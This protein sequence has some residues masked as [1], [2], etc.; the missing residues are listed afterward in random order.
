[1]KQIMLRFSRKFKWKVYINWIHY[2][3]SEGTLVKKQKG[4]RSKGT[5]RK[6]HCWY[7]RPSLLI[8][9]FDLIFVFILINRSDWIWSRQCTDIMIWLFVCLFFTKLF[10]RWDEQIPWF[11]DVSKIP[12]SFVGKSGCLLWGFWIIND[13]CR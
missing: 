10:F 7:A 5:Y 2:S 8:L 1:M 4:W 13:C 11:R 9:I 6:L 12:Y 3:L